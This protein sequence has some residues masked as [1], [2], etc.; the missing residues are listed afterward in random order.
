MVYDL[1][2]GAHSTVVIRVV[3]DDLKE[4]R[5]IGGEIVELLRNTRGTESA[6]IFQEPPSPQITITADRAAAARYGINVSDITN[7]IQ[8]GVGGAIDVFVGDH[9]YNLTLRFPVDTRNNPAA[10][11]ELPHALE[12]QRRAQVPALHAGHDH[13]GANRRRRH[14]REQPPR[15]H[16]PRQ[17]R[18][19]GSRLLSGGGA[20]ADRPVGAFRP[21]QVSH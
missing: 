8:D 3:G 19:P 9:T 14:C 1:I 11:G 6:S 18:G 4:D 10:M 12:R 20:G 16:R 17:P 2:G 7:L 21:D 15:S 13:H 5:R